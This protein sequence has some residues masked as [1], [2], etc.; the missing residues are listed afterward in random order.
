MPLLLPPRKFYLLKGVGC[1]CVC[2]RGGWLEIEFGTQRLQPEREREA[3]IQFES[4]GCREGGSG[5]AG[6]A[7]T[8]RIEV[9]RAQ[10]L[11]QA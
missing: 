6:A 9:R 8:C 10:P 11:P 1:V 4:Y 7:T 2:G 5:G 3:E